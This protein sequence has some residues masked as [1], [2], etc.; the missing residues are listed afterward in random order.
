MIIVLSL[1]K[2]FYFKTCVFLSCFIYFINVYEYCYF[3]KEI[4]LRREEL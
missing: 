4:K 3:V 1:L 2:I